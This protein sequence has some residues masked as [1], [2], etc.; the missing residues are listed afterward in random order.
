MNRKTRNELL[1]LA[2]FF[3]I[4]RSLINALLAEI[5]VLCQQLVVMKRQQKKAPRLTTWDRLLFAL[6][7]GRISPKR[8]L[9]TAIIV[10]PATLLKFHKALINRK[11][12]K[13]FSNKTHKKP[14]P[15][16][17][18]KEIIRLIL[19][20]KQKN[21]S[22]G[23]LRIAM[24]INDIFG[25]N[26]NKDIVRRVLKKYYLPYAGDDGPSWLTF[27]G[28]AKDSLWSM[29]LFRSESI[30]LKTHWI[31]IVMDQFSRRIIGFSVHVGHI[32]GVAV[33]RMLN[34]IIS[35]SNLPK[36][37][38]T[39]NDPFFEFY[40]FKANLRILEIEEIRR[41]DQRNFPASPSQNRT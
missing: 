16:G 29:D 41:V 26:I 31:M 25:V 38:S 15:K 8:L 27:I 2:F 40:R 37:L 6:A 10:K 34:K 36:Y 3:Q 24:Q 7:T 11:Y 28:H 18:S 14:G 21:A 35:S 20:M 39:D 30:S 9:K 19:E 5:L 22:F 13:L 23:W 4:R 12:R 32:D 17:P 1:V 33:C